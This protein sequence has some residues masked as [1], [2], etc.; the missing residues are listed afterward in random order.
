MRSSLGRLSRFWGAGWLAV[1]LIASCGA[2][3]ARADGPAIPVGAAGDLVLPVSRIP[4]DFT[5]QRAKSGP[6]GDAMLAATIGHVA[7]RAF[8]RHGWVGGYRG[9]L[10]GPTTASAPF[11]TYEL[12]GFAT[13]TGAQ[14]SRAAYQSMVLGTPL[15]YPNDAL[16]KSALVWTDTG[17]Y[18]ANQSFFVA[19]IVFRVANVL[20]DVTGFAVG[21]SAQ[22]AND[23]LQQAT[24]VTI[25]CAHWLGSRL[26]ATR[27]TMLPLA[28]LLVAPGMLY[29]RREKRRQ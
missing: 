9:W 22:A 6:I 10:T 23:A 29:R 14:A 17:T 4:A 8:Q 20:A 15:V 3:P 18:G 21:S 1:L 19:E 11:A 26:P 12:Y 25:A 27:H 7:L 28:P 2:L 24:A 5:W 13:D 16:P